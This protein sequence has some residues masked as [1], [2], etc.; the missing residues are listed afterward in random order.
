MAESREA[1]VCAQGGQLYR[2]FVSGEE[3]LAAPSGKLKHLA[4]RDPLRAPAV[5]DRVVYQYGPGDG[6]AIIREVLPRASCFVR[7]AAGARSAV[8]VVAA[9]VTTV[10]LVTA[11]D[12]DFSVRRLERY[13]VQARDAGA[14]PVVAINKADLAPDLAQVVAT[15][16]GALGADVPVHA[17]SATTGTDLAALDPYLGPAAIVALLGSSGVGK[18]TLA[19]ALLGGTSLRTGAIREKDQKGRHTTTDRRL[20]RLPAGGFLLDT[21]GMRELGLWAEPETVAETFTDIAQLAA[22]CRFRDCRHGSEPG[23][24]VAGAVDPGRL[25]SYLELSSEA[26][27]RVGR[28]RR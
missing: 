20:L 28:S 19:N 18:S 8:Q 3:I 14:R 5:G 7:K 11:P 25:R 27:R 12:G 23:C 26:R 22:S 13:L 1:R 17:V 24:A 9:N 6:I 10:L 16:A 2:L 21:P 4:E 15:A